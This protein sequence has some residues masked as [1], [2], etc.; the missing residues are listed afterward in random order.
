ME[1]QKTGILSYGV[2]RGL[3]GQVIGKSWVTIGLRALLVSMEKLLSSKAG[4][5]LAT[6]TTGSRTLAL[7]E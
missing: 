7:G 3:I 2:V 5:A 6:M 1:N 4:C